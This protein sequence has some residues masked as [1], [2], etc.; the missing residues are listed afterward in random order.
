MT[1]AGIP[2]ATELL[3]ISRVTTA[4]APMMQLSPILTPGSIYAPLPIYTLFPTVIGATISILSSPK[5]P[6]SDRTFTPPSCVKK[7]VS[8]AIKQSSPTVTKYGSVP[9]A[10]IEQFSLVRSPMDTPF[11]RKYFSFVSYDRLAIIARILF[12]I[13]FKI[14]IICPLYQEFSNISDSGSREYSLLPFL[15]RCYFS[16]DYLTI[17]PSAPKV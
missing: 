15:I 1:R 13:V 12:N 7:Q 3:G 2:T 8:A 11:L 16:N 4:A 17:F 5:Y 14:F 10:L 6:R 9:N